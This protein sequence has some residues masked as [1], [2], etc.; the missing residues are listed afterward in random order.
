MSEVQT[1]FVRSYG[2]RKGRSLSKDDA[3]AVVAGIAGITVS[4]SEATTF[5]TQADE[6]WIEI[7]SGNGEHVIERA[8]Q[9]PDIKIVA[10]EPFYDGAAA[11]AAKIRKHNIQ[12]LRV[13]VGDARY[14]LTELPAQSL[15][16]VYILFPDPWPKK[17]HYNRRVISEETLV[18]LKRVLK[19]G[20]LLRTATDNPDYVEHILLAAKNSQALHWTA[21][22]PKDFMNAWEGYRPTKYHRRAELMGERAYF[23][24]FQA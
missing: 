16:M 7:G 6:A 15:A 5:L 20:G 2:R 22:S 1:R 9:N 24:E 4:L 17:R 18:E 10:C 23:L 14:L 8:L 12:N 3:D 21:Q 11:T 19:K 13:H